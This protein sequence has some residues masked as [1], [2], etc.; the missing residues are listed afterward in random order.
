MYS[1]N[2]NTSAVTGTAGF[3]D[4]QFNPGNSSSQPATATISNFI[5]GTLGATTP[6]IGNV[7]GT[8]PG[9]VTFVNSAGL[10]EY[11]QGFTY[12]SS[13]SFLLTL[14]GLALDNPNGTATAGTKFGVGY[15]TI[16]RT[17]FLRIRG[18]SADLRARLKST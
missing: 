2:V 8:L 6:N 13:F 14:S 7:S 12:A 10:N 15:T 17:R 4:F 5:G 9:P 1:V 3:L 11:F 18:P 16:T